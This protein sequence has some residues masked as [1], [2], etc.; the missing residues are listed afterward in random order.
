METETYSDDEALLK[1]IDNGEE[2]IKYTRSF[3]SADKGKARKIMEQYF[4]Y[5]KDEKLNT[6]KYKKYQVAHGYLVFFGVGLFLWLK[7]YLRVY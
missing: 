2:E 4:Y 6:F 3:E 1:V 7:G 5:M